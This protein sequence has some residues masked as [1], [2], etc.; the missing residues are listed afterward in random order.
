VLLVLYCYMSSITYRDEIIDEDLQG[1]DIVNKIL[2]NR[3][4]P[5]LMTFLH[6][7]HPENMSLK[8]F[9]YQKEFEKISPILSH[10]YE[11]KSSVVVYMDY[12]A[13][14]ITGGSIVWE[15]FHLLGFRVMP[16]I[17]HRVH[18]GYGFSR[19]GIDTV[20]KEFAPFLIISVDHGITAIDQIHYAKSQNIHVIV[21]DHHTKL[22]NKPGADGVFHITSLSGS[23]VGYFFAKEVCNYILSQKSSHFINKKN[24]DR[25]SHNFRYDYVT[26]AAI[27]TIAD[28]VPLVGPSRSIAKYGLD[29]CARIKNTGLK[30]MMKEAKIE[31]KKL[32]PYDVGFIIA[33]RINAV[34][35]VEHALDALRLLC[36]TSETRAAELAINIGLLNVQ[37][38]SMVQQSVKEAH[39]QVELLK[40]KG[41]L[42]KLL[43]VFSEDWHEGIIG[44]I[45]SRLMEEYYRPVFAMTAHNGIVKGSARSI[46]S[47]HIT[48]FLSEHKEYFTGYGGHAQAAG[49]SFVREKLDLFCKETLLH[50]EEQ[51]QDKQLIRQYKGDI[52]IPLILTSMEL[53]KMIE[54][55]EPFGVGNPQPLFVSDIEVVG[56]RLMGSKNK[57]IKITGKQ[58]HL[59]HFPVD[60]VFFNRSVA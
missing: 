14:G 58:P 3:D 28:L 19:I 2:S 26:I 50:A 52:K 6:P 34:G 17:P 10:A 29:D 39:E 22:K 9:G 49:F 16:Y 1:E 57:H 38:Q 30:Q 25:L 12:D 54:E 23:G 27:G 8:D 15:T 56:V 5:D 11:E 44:L 4:I 24:R 36:T 41:N 37:R 32:S 42:P 43:I 20:I 53:V 33:P 40:R 7:P 59:D 13:D 46:S 31:N 47:F 21:T 35:R 55:L 51:I 18:E 48:D 60:F 45:A